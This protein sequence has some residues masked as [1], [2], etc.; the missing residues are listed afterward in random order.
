MKKLLTVALLLL[1]FSLAF[2]AGSKGK[3]YELS[4]ATNMQ[5]PTVRAGSTQFRI[6][7]GFDQAP[8]GC[9]KVYAAIAPED[10]HMVSLLLMAQAQDLEVIV[11]LNHLSDGEYYSGRCYVSY[12]SL[13]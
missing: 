11:H 9:D 3:V 6:E 8:E 4:M 13:D 5:G 12:L 1:P 7:G 10:S 2:G